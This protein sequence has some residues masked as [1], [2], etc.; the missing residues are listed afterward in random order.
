M[1]LTIDLIPSDAPTSTPG[2]NKDEGCT[3]PPRLCRAN[4]LL[5]SKVAEMKANI[6]KAR[7]RLAAKVAAMKG[8]IVKGCHGRFRPNHGVGGSAPEPH[9][10]HHHHAGSHH[11]RHG[12]TARKVARIFAQVVLPILVG[13]AAGMAAS[14]LGMLLGRVIAFFWIRYR[15]GGQRTASAVIRDSEEAIVDG[16]KDGLMDEQMEHPPV[17]EELEGAV[18]VKV[19]AQKEVV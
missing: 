12:S 10:P 3:L 18:A 11:H 14:A 15:R 5:A 6:A 17:Y 2:E 19:Q 16:E 8:G 9:H 4:A 1:I 7:A 13:V